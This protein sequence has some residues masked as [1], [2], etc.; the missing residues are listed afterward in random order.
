MSKEWLNDRERALENEY[1]RRKDQELI[2][3]LREQ[4]RLEQERRAL[5]DQLGSADDRLPAELQQAGFTDAGLALLHLIPL[6]DVAW[7]D[8]GVTARERDLV[9]A[10]AARR[11]VAEDTPE[12]R[13]L[14]GWL[15]RRPDQQVFETAYEG[16]RALLAHQETSVRTT[17]RLELVAWTTRVAE[18]TG[19]ILGMLP[20]SHEER[21][22]LDRIAELIT[23]EPRDAGVAAPDRT[24]GTG[25]S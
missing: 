5:R 25:P 12:H 19:G 2:A 13:R 1:F 21:E 20:I 18:A 7:A 22:C 16:I 9:L 15:K 14:E 23:T 4:G 17:T 10:L 3:R 6:V 11:G 8:K 24:E